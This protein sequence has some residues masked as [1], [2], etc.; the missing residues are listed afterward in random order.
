MIGDLQKTTTSIDN[1]NR[2]IT[3]R[4]RTEEAL[5]K[6]EEQYRIQFEG[7]GLASGSYF[8]CLTVEGRTQIQKMMLI[9]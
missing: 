7:S 6:A 9:R 2:E 8:I 3:E 5:R 1:L 4:K